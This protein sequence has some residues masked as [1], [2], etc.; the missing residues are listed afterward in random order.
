MPRRRLNR[1]ADLKG[2]AFSDMKRIWN[3][4]MALLL[5]LAMLLPMLGMAQPVMAAEAGEEFMT[6]AD[7]AWT[8]DDVICAT[9]EPELTPVS[10]GSDTEEEPVIVTAT[11]TYG[12]S[13]ADAQDAAGDVRESDTAVVPGRKGMVFGVRK[14]N[15]TV[16]EVPTAGYEQVVPANGEAARVTVSDDGSGN[17]TVEFLNAEDNGYVF[18]KTGGIGTMPLYAIGGM[19]A[20][21]GC[22]ALM[23]IRKRKDEDA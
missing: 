12:E 20:L 2:G 19:L 14:A 21:C 11:T 3:N 5:T 4:G 17:N 7:R 9:Q 13:K 8:D 22:I 18:P 6:E 1:D 15:N 23:S 10:D 16:A